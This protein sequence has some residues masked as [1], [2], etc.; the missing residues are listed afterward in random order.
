MIVLDTNVLSELMKPQPDLRV[1]E[2]VR[3]KPRAA[4]YTTSV[5]QA[6]VLAGIGMLPKG[7]RREALRAAADELFRTDFA[8]RVLPFDQAAARTYAAIVEERRDAGRPLEGFDGLIAA[9]ARSAGY[10]VATRNVA[11]FDG[12]GVEVVNPWGTEHQG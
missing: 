7:R 5:V 6:E 10:A 4:L 9:A 1:F 12:C 2:W 11:D 3:A 8:G